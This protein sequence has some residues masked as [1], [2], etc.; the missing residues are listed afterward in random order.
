MRSTPTR[1]DETVRALQQFAQVF[2]LIVRHLPAAEWRCF[3]LAG[4]R[5]E[6]SDYL[7]GHGWSILPDVRLDIFEPG[8]RFR[9][10]VDRRH[11]IMPKRFSI[12]SWVMS[13][14]ASA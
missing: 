7:F 11:R 4:A 9:R 3:Q 8:E 5:Q 6:P 14:P 13:R 1:Y 10:P 12:S 2:A